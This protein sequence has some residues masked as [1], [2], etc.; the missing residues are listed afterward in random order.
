[1]PPVTTTT[2]CFSDPNS[3]VVTIVCG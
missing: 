3:P 2:V 1:V